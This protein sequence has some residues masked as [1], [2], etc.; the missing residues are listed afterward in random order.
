M[1]PERMILL[2]RESSHLV[3][4]EHHYRARVGGDQGDNLPASGFHF[5]P[6]VCEGREAV[7]DWYPF[8]P[9][10]Q[11]GSPVPPVSRQSW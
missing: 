10:S 9:G 7:I 6:A 11:S 5:L 2:L 4:G 3:A 8:D 1:T